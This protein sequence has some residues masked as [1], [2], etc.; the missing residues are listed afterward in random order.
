MDKVSFA[1]F[2]EELESIVKTS[3][4]VD[5]AVNM[6]KGIGNNVSNVAHNWAHP[7]QGMKEG[8]KFNFSPGEAWNRGWKGRAGYGLNAGLQGLGLYMGAKDT[9]ADVDPSGEGR[10]KLRR[11]LSVAGDQIGN[12]LGAKHGLVAG[13]G[14]SM[15]GGKVGDTIGRGIDKLRGYKPTHNVG[16]VAYVPDYVR[17]VHQKG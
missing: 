5:G 6:A 2:S 7:V 13:I 15:L 11:G 9:M 12:L 14:S 3:G 16:P 4:F 8:L 1:S 17:A 10:S